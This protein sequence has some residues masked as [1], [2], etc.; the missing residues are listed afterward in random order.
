MINFI[1]RA[2]QRETALLILPFS[3]FSVARFLLFLGTRQQAT[4]FFLVLS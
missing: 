3:S 1:V 4:Q 2:L